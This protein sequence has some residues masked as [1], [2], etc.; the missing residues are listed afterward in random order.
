MAYSLCRKRDLSRFL[1]LITFSKFSLDTCPYSS[2]KTTVSTSY[3]AETSA[4]M[5]CV[6]QCAGSHG[7]GL[8]SQMFSHMQGYHIRVFFF[9]FFLFSGSLSDTDGGDVSICE[10]RPSH[11]GNFS[12]NV[13]C[14]MGTT[15]YQ[16]VYNEDNIGIKRST[17]CLPSIVK[18]SM[19]VY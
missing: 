10:K 6:Y 4:C 16:V 17:K 1:F 19:N 8:Q 12:L 7:S 9:S 11:I 5:V 3:W 15:N 2:S 14:K 13:F 18:Y